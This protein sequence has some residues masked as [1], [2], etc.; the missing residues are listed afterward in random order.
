MKMDI[1]EKF[2]ELIR[3]TGRIRG[4]F[5]I[6]PKHKTKAN[7]KRGQKFCNC[8][9]QDEEYISQSIKNIQYKL[10]GSKMGKEAK[11]EMKRPSLSV[12]RQHIRSADYINK[13]DLDREISINWKKEEECVILK[14]MKEEGK[15]TVTIRE[16]G[17]D[18]T[19]KCS[20]FLSEGNK[21]SSLILVLYQKCLIGATTSITHI[22]IKRNLIW[23]SVNYKT[24][25]FK[26]GDCFMILTSARNTIPH[27]S[28]IPKA[29]P[30]PRAT[31]A[32]SPFILL[33]LK[34]SRSN[35][36]RNTYLYKRFDQA[37]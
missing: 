34:R 18:S 1:V 2:S 10:F 16:E 29:K 22:M 12:S 28:I 20:G 36:S 21:I 3:G 23:S 15:V 30:R 26:A 32:Q 5:N 35:M 17:R 13:S 14:K 27:R 4:N 25:C 6:V 33:K 31:I 9:Q 7:S 11:L 37:I 24:D 8:R 19:L